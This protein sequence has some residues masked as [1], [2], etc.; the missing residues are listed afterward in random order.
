M[1]SKPF[2]F[3][4]P[5]QKYGDFEVTR[6]V[7]IPELQS[8]LIELVH[9]P[10]AAQVMHIANED[11]EN[12]F[13]LSF[14]TFPEKSDGVAHI[15]EHTVLCGSKKFPVKDPFFSMTRR[16][17]NTFMNALTGSDFTCY[18]AATQV[19]KDFY[20]LLEV[21]I[22]AVF[23]PNLKRLSF[24]QEGH[25]LEFAHPNDPLSPL[26]YKGVVFNEMKGVM[27]SP[28]SRLGEAMHEA[29]YP[30][31][32]YGKN[33]GGNPKIIPELTYEELVD[34]HKKFYHPSHCLFFFYGNF[35]LQ[36]H[37]DF[38]SEYALKGI[39][40]APP[41]SHLPM[42]TKYKNPVSL[43]TH[44]P[45]AGDEKEQ[46]KTYVAF[47][48][49]TCPITDQEQVLALSILE[50]VL[51]DTDASPLKM[52]LLKSGL[53]KLVSSHI[54]TEIHE[55]C[56]IIT[57]RGCEADTAD[58]C[59]LLLHKTL[60]DIVRK[61]I[62]LNLIEN[63]IHQL[64]IYRSEIGGNHAPF[65]L[66]LFMRSGLLKQHGVLPEEGLK[67]HTLFDA[68]HKKA[69]LDPAYFTQLIQQTLLDNP[70]RARVVM[71][72]DKHL[73][74]QE[75]EEER[76]LLDNIRA[77]LTSKETD[78]IIRQSHE[79]AI[80][81]THQQEESP[82][83]LP[84]LSLE[85]IPKLSRNFELL[86]EETGPLGVYHHNCF[87]N[88]ILFTDLTY[89]LPQ[90]PIED[91]SYVRL[92]CVLLTQMGCGGRNYIDNLDFIQANT[93]GISASL[94]FNL[95]AQ[96][97]LQF[98]PSIHIRSK[99]LY[100]K[101][102]KLFSLMADLTHSV[103][104]TDLARLREV[105][106]KHYTSLESSLAQNAMKY[107]INLS[108][109]PLDTAS[110]IA[111]AWYGLEYY[112]KIKHI[113]SDLHNHL[114]FLSQKMQELHHKLLGLENPNLVLSCDSEFYHE[115]KNHD[116][117]GLSKIPT[118]SYE[119][120]KCDCPSVKIPSQGRIIPSPV[121]FIGKVFKTV[122]F[123]HP[124]SP[125]LALAASLLDN[126]TLHPIIREQGGAYGSG[127]VSNALSGNFYFYSYRDPNISK[128]LE[129]FDIAINDLAQGKFDEQDLE[130]AKFDIIQGLDEPVPPG[131]RG[132]HAYGWLRE[133]KT[134]SIRQAFRD[135]L[136][137]TTP[138]QIINAVNEHIIPRSQDGVTV[139]F[140]GQEL[141]EKENEILQAKGLPT[142]AIEK[143]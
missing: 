63:A 139:V 134:Q 114:A 32:T 20:N 41:L 127:A 125:V 107:A 119:S 22:D 137:N 113:A 120:W 46:A 93:G 35:A 48:W 9:I 60:S 71:T 84:K 86:R 82:D 130:E 143:I 123:T 74:A 68:V 80:F 19:K 91:L 24:L 67:I 97:A 7:D 136:L 78:H 103:D 2:H 142:L 132:E 49:L 100:R 124:D 89:K 14:Q 135:G 34:F 40:K 27:T 56:W 117:Y 94:F 70:H 129:A 101:S 38:I 111:N 54:D 76:C 95:Q 6:C 72:P 13:C 10:T 17:L 53:C 4:T 26:E 98:Y 108:A 116:F 121:A 77:K 118:R 87:T 140:G 106:L 122:S 52:A 45:I 64:E 31:L 16:S 81:Q 15:L 115:L 99:A 44:Y 43:V 75:H 90:I 96:D 51:L 30:Q 92:F 110:Y 3:N 133:G 11:S 109:S 61:G 42:Q 66:S 112:W 102:N 83:M 59:E 18:P 138:E 88:K 105:V 73:A 23:F 47:G 25:R 36:G 58:E 28:G 33:F 55:G 104:F 57:L 79:L 62:P 37:L 85:D 12:L 69:V 39:T 126:L 128:S 29:L 131:L 65:G 21:Y 5:G 141:L 50:I 1:H 8:R